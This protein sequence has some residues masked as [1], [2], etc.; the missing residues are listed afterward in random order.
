MPATFPNPVV[1]AVTTVLSDLGVVTPAGKV[2]KVDVRFSNIGSADAYGDLVVT[3]GSITLQRAK[4]YP[5]PFQAAGSAPDM[6]L[7]LILPAGFKLQARASANSTIE[8]GITNI[9]ETDLSDFT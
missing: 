8:A 5:V 3:N 7:Q 9:V 2:R 6:E 4:N 1:L